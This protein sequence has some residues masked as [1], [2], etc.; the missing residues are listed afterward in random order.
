MLLLLKRHSRLLREDKRNNSPGS[1]VSVLS[2]DF[3]N[4]VADSIKKI[5]V[6]APHHQNRAR[7]GFEIVSP[8]IP[9]S[10][11]SKMVLSARPESEDQAFAAAAWQGVKS[12]MLAA[13]E[14]SQFL[15]TGAGKAMPFNIF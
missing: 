10:Q 11:K 13:G 4:A 7:I 8:A 1:A 5:T 6:V 2:L 12:G 14:H 3:G 9:S 15:I